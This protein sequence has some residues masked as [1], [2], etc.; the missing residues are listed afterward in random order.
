MWNFMGEL[1]IILQT[2]HLHKHHSLGI[3]VAATWCCSL[4]RT[5]I[6]WHIRWT[7]HYRILHIYIYIYIYILYK[8]PKK[9]CLENENCNFVKLQHRRI[10]HFFSIMQYCG[11]PVRTPVCIRYIK[12]YKETSCVSM[13]SWTRVVSSHLGALDKVYAFLFCFFWCSRGYSVTPKQNRKQ[14]I[15]I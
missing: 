5:G 10:S 2:F 9:Q 11:T 3:K 12:K 15:P 14:I 8:P 1:K 6:M 13:S 7:W 4:G